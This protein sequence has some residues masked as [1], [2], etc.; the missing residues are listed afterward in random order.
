MISPSAAIDI[1]V[2]NH[3]HSRLC[4]H[5]MG[6]MEEY[7]LAGLG[8]GLKKIIFLEHFEI[9]IKYFESTWLREDEFAGYH[10]EGCR[11]SEKYQGKIEIGTGVEVGVNPDRLPETI[12]FLIKFKWDRIGLS[13]HYLDTGD[14]HVNMVSRRPE[15]IAL[16]EKIGV[17]KVAAAY[18][19][20][21]QKA[22]AIIPADVVCHL[23]AVLR[24]CPSFSFSQEHFEK[25]HEILMVMGAKDI[26]L[27]VN[28]S[29]FVLR[30]EPF[31]A[32]RILKQAQKMGVG[33]LAGSDAHRPEDVG[34]YF[35]RLPLL[36]D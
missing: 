3:V 7:V 26:A 9:E 19:T 6:E 4:H 23:D 22:L 13:Y 32:V 20:G 16:M 8:A 2:D 15:N 21:L 24:H 35:D 10:R 5:A 14:G 33:L 12:D 30:N 36:L 27:E 28:T 18:F 11:L 25:V 34:R 1:S 31:P 29:G 17:E